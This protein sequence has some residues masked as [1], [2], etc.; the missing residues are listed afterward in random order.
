[1][2]LQSSRAFDDLSVSVV[3]FDQSCTCLLRPNDSTET[4]ENLPLLYLIMFL[5]HSGSLND[6]SLV[7][8]R[9]Q[10]HFHTVVLR[11]RTSSP[12]STSRY[13]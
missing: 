4:H 10:S 12:G 5:K 11:R 3:Y 2:F 7:T 13:M 1:M 6:G 8:D 9:T